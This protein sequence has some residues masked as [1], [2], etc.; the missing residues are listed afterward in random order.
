MP[1]T[2]L[3]KA[4][5]FVAEFPENEKGTYGR[6]I[7]ESK[8]QSS[9]Y[10][11]ASSRPQRCTPPTKQ[12]PF[13]TPPQDKQSFTN[14]PFSAFRLG[15]PKRLTRPVSSPSIS[16]TLSYHTKWT[17]YTDPS[18][19]QRSPS[20]KRRKSSSSSPCSSPTRS[21]ENDSL[22]PSLSQPLSLGPQRSPSPSRHKRPN[23]SPEVSPVIT[24]TKVRKQ[25]RPPPIRSTGPRRNPTPIIGPRPT[26]SPGFYMTLPSSP[27]RNTRNVDPLPPLSAYSMDMANESQDLYQKLSIPEDYPGF[28]PSQ[29]HPINKAPVTCAPV[30]T[31]SF[32]ESHQT[33]TNS[34]PKLDHHVNHVPRP[35]STPPLQ[36][37][38]PPYGYNNSSGG[39]F[40]TNTPPPYPMYNKFP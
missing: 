16:Q 32:T 14:P 30:R 26:S 21:Q 38:N 20:P 17:N 2:T 35:E 40:F 39:I 3:P 31:K 5:E 7:A 19:L 18:Q 36:V 11:N 13:S 37:T 29:S 27:L 25:R 1:N 24:T 8:W 28:Y 23:S 9:M 15:S 6:R 12:R 22:L 34:N 33:I 10:S 4:W